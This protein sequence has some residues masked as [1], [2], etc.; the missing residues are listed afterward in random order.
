MTNYFLPRYKYFNTFMLSGTKCSRNIQAQRA[1]RGLHRQFPRK[2][3]E[4]SETLSA[5]ND[6]RGAPR[7]SGAVNGVEPLTEEDCFNNSCIIVGRAVFLISVFYPL[8]SAALTLSP[9][10]KA[11]ILFFYGTH[12]FVLYTCLGIKKVK[13]D[14]FLK[15][16]LQL[17]QRYAILM[18]TKVIFF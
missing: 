3:G 5:L 4:L 17:L 10:E 6:K 18:I 11:H 12:F 2:T 13:Q 8:S 15:S 9:K 1:A 16:P 7:V 14:D